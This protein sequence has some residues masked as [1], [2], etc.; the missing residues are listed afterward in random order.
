VI[1]PV[2]AAAVHA[3][4]TIRGAVGWLAFRGSLHGLVT[5]AVVVAGPALAAA[6]STAG[7]SHPLC[8]LPAARLGAVR[9]LLPEAEKAIAAHAERERGPL[10]RSLATYQARAGEP[11]TALTTMA[12]VP[13]L[14]D[15]QNRE[16]LLQEIAVA[17]AR[18]GDRAAT[19]QTL[20]RM[21]QGYPADQAVLAMARMLVRCGE[22]PAALHAAA[23]ASDESAHRGVVLA[24]AEAQAETG[25]PAGALQ[26]LVRQGLLHEP[27]MASAV[28]GLHLRNGD[29][30]TAERVGGTLLPPERGL[31]LVGLAPDRAYS[32][33][34]AGALAAVRQMPD[35]P[36]RA[37]FFAGVV[38]GQAAGGDLPGARRTAEGL[39]DP[40]AKDMA[41]VTVAQAYAARGDVATAL[42][43]AGTITRPES[44]S[45]AL[46]RIALEQ[47]RAGHVTGALATAVRLTDVR[48][49]GNLL[50][51]LAERLTEGG[52]AAGAQAALGAITDPESRQRARHL[53]RVAAARRGDA[54]P[55][56]AVAA[57]ASSAA[58]RWQLLGPALN[59]LLQIE[60]PLTEDVFD[61][62][63]FG[64]RR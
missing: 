1:G 25:D 64:K 27:E 46:R 43:I 7:P 38:A 60:R 39:A 4:R 57:A 52:D 23:A 50:G 49:R 42:T 8:A 53:M 59:D 17:Q 18:A 48:A 9:Q 47:A 35:S 54:G 13:P 30:A 5:L 63:F 20:A 26:T 22:L 15:V 41:L 19:R 10:L 3:I 37:L 61:P 6:Q 12:T 16:L 34:V 62:A 56:L 44:A 24:I 51:T 31:F 33:D 28:A 2:A 32:G 14:P 40:L 21:T 58:Q 36:F 11:A 45:D 29:L 55:L